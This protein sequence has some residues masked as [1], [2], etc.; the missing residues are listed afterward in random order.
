MRYRG[1][2]LI[3]IHYSL[4]REETLGS[5]WKD[6]FFFA[7]HWFWLNK[8]NWCDE[9]ERINITKS[10]KWCLILNL[11]SN[12][13]RFSS[14]RWVMR[15]LVFTHSDSSAELCF[16]FNVPSM[17]IRVDV[18]F[19][20]AAQWAAASCVAEGLCPIHINH[21]AT[22]GKHIDEAALGPL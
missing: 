19:D 13:S 21:H 16:E 4:Q 1:R 8:Y 17:C 15:C 18:C 6:S 12:Q 10:G 3:L 22:P 7:M 5:I 14:T 9:W 2:S 11:T 20:L